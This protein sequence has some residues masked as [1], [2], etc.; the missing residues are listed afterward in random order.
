MP[1]EY[2]EA[3]RGWIARDPGEVAVLER[4][5]ATLDAAPEAPACFTCN[6][7]RYVLSR[8]R[9]PG[10]STVIEGFQRPVRDVEACPAC[11]A[12]KPA[13][14]IAAAGI[15]SRYAGCSLDT[16][17]GDPEAVE[18]VRAWLAQGAPRSLLLVGGNGRGKTGLAISA[19]RA[20]CE[21]GTAA[22]FVSVVELLDEVR[23]TY[24]SD[25]STERV[26]AR[27]KTAPVLVLDDLMAARVTDW[28]REAIGGLI[29]A[30]RTAQL[31][32]VVTCDVDSGAVAQAYG[33][34]VASR[35]L[36]SWLVEVGGRDLRGAL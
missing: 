31:V 21:A 9:R 26:V 23:A 17:P 12:P 28:A 1:V 20:L 7:A 33:A 29:E 18:A 27:Y 13:D 5:V 24:G 2:A 6:G 16:F 4:E 15:P 14:L 11:N 25:A 19:V 10:G 35:L 22:R 32:T 30:R 3:K 8:D 34:R 36:E